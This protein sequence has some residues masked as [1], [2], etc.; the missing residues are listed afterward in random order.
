MAVNLRVDGTTRACSRD[1]MVGSKGCACTYE[2]VQQFPVRNSNLLGSLAGRGH[3]DPVTCPDPGRL[4]RPTVSWVNGLGREGTR[5][6]NDDPRRL[7]LGYR[8]SS[9]HATWMGKVHATPSHGAPTSYDQVLDSYLR[10]RLGM[11][12]VRITF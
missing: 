10:V 5:D 8:A 4:E 2:G 6:D 11:S 3:T 1:Q 7:L 12:M 9:P